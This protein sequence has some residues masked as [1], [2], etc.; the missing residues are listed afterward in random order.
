MRVIT[1]GTADAF[2]AAGRLH[3]AVVVRSGDVTGLVDCGPSIL[4]ALY[5]GKVGADDIDFMLITHLHGDHIGGV[6]MLLL[7]YQ[8][9]SRRTRP[10]VVIGTALCRSRL[11]ALTALMYAEITKKRRR[12]AVDY[13]TIRPGGTMSVCGMRIRAYRMQHIEREQCLGYRIERGGKSVAITGDTTWCE[14]VAEMSRG[15]DLLVTECT[16]YDRRTPVHMSYTRL[17]EHR[18]EIGAKRVVLTHVGD[19]LLKNRGKV[20]HRIAR[21]GERFDV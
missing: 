11:E 6:P 18:D 14:S 20:R 8:Y 13:R 7:D 10:L 19:D 9:R 21:D 16:D 2:G 5:R 3:S 4:P 15:A 12:F 17:R 1:L